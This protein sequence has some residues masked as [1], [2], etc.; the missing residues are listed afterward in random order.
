MAYSLKVTVRSHARLHMGIIDVNGGLGRLYGSLGL[1]I[2]TP[3]VVVESS[4]SNEFLVEGED[5]E[6]AKDAASKFLSHFG[7]EKRC[8]INIVTTIPAHVGLGSGTQLKLA[9]GRSLAKLFDLE[10]SSIEISRIL[11]RGI[12]SGIGTALFEKG[13][14]VVDGGV[15]Y[16]INNGNSIPPEIVRLE[17][18]EDWHFVIAI[19]MNEKGLSDTA[20]ALAFEKLSSAQPEVVGQISRMLLMK[21]FPSIVEQDIAAFGSSLNAIQTLVGGCFSHLQGGTFAGSYVESIVK[22]MLDN[23]AYGAGQSSWGPAVYGVVKGTT[24]AKLLLGKVEAYLDTLSGGSVFF[25]KCSNNGAKVVV[26]QN[27]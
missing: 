16:P 7:I 14:F 24:D 20:E 25:S 5:K 13:G 1:A 10:I 9:V 19:P 4:T 22:L 18:P 17:F 27:L 3:D 11:G 12:V 23:G 8:H 26:D 15:R 2:L 21:M 6:R